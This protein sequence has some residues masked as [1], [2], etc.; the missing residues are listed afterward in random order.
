MV[1]NQVTRPKNRVA[2]KKATSLQWQETRYTPSRLTLLPPSLIQHDSSPN[3]EG[4][5]N[6]QQVPHTK[7]ARSKMS[8]YAT[9]RNVQLFN[10]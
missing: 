8:T 5:I 2:T 9:A 7:A 6:Q 4:Q 3:P 1:H 10:R